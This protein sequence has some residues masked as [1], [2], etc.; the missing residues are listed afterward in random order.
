LIDTGN[1]IDSWKAEQVSP[2][3]AYIGPTG[4]NTHMSNQKLGNLL[5]YG[6][7]GMPARPH[8]RSVT[9]WLDKTGSKMLG[10]EVR[11]GIFGRS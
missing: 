2:V 1:Y 11:D 8:M 6:T 7:E 9:R 5:E 10:K 3:E 4:Q